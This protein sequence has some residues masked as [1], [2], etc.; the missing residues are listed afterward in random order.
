MANFFGSIDSYTLNLLSPKAYQGRRL[1][2]IKGSFGVATLWFHPD[3]ATLPNNEKTQGQDS[4]RVYYHLRDWASML[5]ML[6]NES[7]VYFNYSDTANAAQIL[8]GNEPVGEEESAS[9]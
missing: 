7:P 8:T 3:D 4:F 1:M 5:D 2:V 9:N 6:R